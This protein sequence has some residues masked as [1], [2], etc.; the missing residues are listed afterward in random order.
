MA[1][2]AI[3]VSEQM[4]QRPKNEFE[5]DRMTLPFDPRGSIET[6]NR[7]V[8]D[9]KNAGNFSVFEKRATPEKAN[10]N[11]KQDAAIPQ[12]LEDKFNTEGYG[13]GLDANPMEESRGE[14]NK[15]AMLNDLLKKKQ[16]AIQQEDEEDFEAFLVKL[17][18]K[19]QQDIGAFMEENKL[20]PE[21]NNRPTKQEAPPKQRSFPEVESDQMHVSREHTQSQMSKMASVQILDAPNERILETTPESIPPNAVNE[22]VRS[23]LKSA[24]IESQPY[25]E[26]ASFYSGLDQ[27]IQEA[28]PNNR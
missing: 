20:S 27:S 4:L 6:S 28:K 3:Q 13:A 16:F 11:L 9:G 17:N 15:L 18:Q 14:E 10:S 8:W 12:R 7:V 21:S 25:N 22:D 23:I 26:E 1:A 5:T 2:E 19:R 24:K